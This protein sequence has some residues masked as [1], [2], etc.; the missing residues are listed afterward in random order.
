VKR[1]ASAPPDLAGHLA[2]LRQQTGLTQEDFA[3]R[4]GITYKYY[5]AIEAG[6]RSDLRFS[7]LARL[8]RAHGMR[9]SEF[10]FRMEAPVPALVA[11]RPS[12]SYRASTRRPAA[13]KKKAS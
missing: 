2:Q 10:F 3:E 6:R 8:A 1:A 7:T 5:Q 9:L 11:E 13:R 12:V 4:A